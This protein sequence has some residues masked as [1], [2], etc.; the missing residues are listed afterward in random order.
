MI[1]CNLKGGLGNQLFQIFTT[2]SYALINKQ[3]FGF[4]DIYDLKYGITKRHTYWHNFL[5]TL[6]RFLSNSLPSMIIL[7]EKSFEY[8][9]LPKSIEEHVMLDGYFQSPKYFE[10]YSGF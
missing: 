1:S 2:I 3:P 6:K 8:N 10:N 9:E 5:S 7:K 4:H